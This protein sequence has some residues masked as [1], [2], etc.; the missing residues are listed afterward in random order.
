MNR[1]LVGNWNRCVELARGTYLCIFHQDDLMMPGNVAA[2]VTFLDEHPTAGFVHSNVLQVGPRGELL[3]EWWSPP[4]GPD[5]V[6]LQAGAVVL[7]KLL[8]G[9]NAVCAPSV[10]MRRECLDAIGPFDGRL[11]DTADWEMWISEGG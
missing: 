9:G 6:G 10:V 5:D 7:E 1:G 3:S 8:R 11:P 2:K 4:L